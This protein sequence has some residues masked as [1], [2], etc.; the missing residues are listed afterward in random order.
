MKAEIK[1]YGR[2][3][4]AV[5]EIEYE[6]QNVGDLITEIVRDLK[7]KS[8]DVYIKCWNERISRWEDRRIISYGSQSCVETDFLTEDI[9]KAKIKKV[10]IVGGSI[11]DD[12]RNFLIEI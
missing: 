4:D 8:G 5:F 10:R 6:A 9:K 11:W 7:K 1:S 12:K 3:G 2:M